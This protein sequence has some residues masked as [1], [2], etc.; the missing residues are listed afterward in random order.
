MNEPVYLDDSRN[1]LIALDQTLLPHEQHRLELTT[2]E[3]VWE[4]IKTLRVRG[5]PVIGVSAAIGAYVAARN[6]VATTL[7]GFTAE[8]SKLCAYLNS[9]RPTAVN[10]SWALRQ[11]QSAL[12]GDTRDAWL[13][14]LRECALEIYRNA[15]LDTESIAAH[16]L[17]LVK[18][19][20]GILTH[21]NAGRLA[22]MGKGTATA[23]I[24]AAHDAGYNPRVYAD[25][26][27]PLMQGARL[28]A[29]ELHQAGLDVTLIC[30]NMSA[31]LMKSGAIDAV[32]VGADR[33]AAN[34]DAANK[35]G[36]LAVAILAKQYCVPFYVCAPYSTIDAGTPTGADIVIEQRDPTEVSH[37]WFSRPS[38]SPGVKVYNPAFD[39]TDAELITAFVTE[40]GIVRGPYNFFG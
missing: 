9:S 17:T 28:T 32:F 15:I 25:E 18:R 8:F 10:L 13:E 29:F 30:D 7:E 16:G 35:I 36:T 21:C 2:A 38:T 23:P 40:R 39:V 27:R 19:D 31:S 12:R 24:Y 1:A 33:V 3:Q 34:G 20:C 37:M 26:T 14:S 4:A 22:C 11:M 5:A 6:I